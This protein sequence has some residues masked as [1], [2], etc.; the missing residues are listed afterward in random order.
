[1]TYYD[2]LAPVIFF[3]VGIPFKSLPNQKLN[4]PYGYASSYAKK[5]EAV[6]VM[7]KKL[8]LQSLWWEL[9]F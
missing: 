4:S 6:W 5:S 8:Y 3:I 2:F 1:M 9:V 7:H